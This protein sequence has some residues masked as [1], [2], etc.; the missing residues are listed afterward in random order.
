ME[1][2]EA[3]VDNA[4]TVN[5]CAPLILKESNL[6]CGA[7]LNLAAR[8]DTINWRIASPLKGWKCGFSQGL[9]NDQE[10]VPWKGAASWKV[11]LSRSVEACTSQED[12][13]LSQGMRGH[14]LLSACHE[15]RFP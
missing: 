3:G 13:K 9:S 15:R 2:N 4:V 7:G 12:L 1:S 8:P 11:L 6:P 10:T 14:L 5:E